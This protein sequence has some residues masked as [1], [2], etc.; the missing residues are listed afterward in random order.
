M[1][2]LYINYYVNFGGGDYS[3]N[4]QYEMQVTEEEYKA[5]R[6]AYINEE[7]L[8]NDDYESIV[9]DVLERAEEEVADYEVEEYGYEE[10]EY[11]P[12]EI[13]I[14]VADMQ[15]L[16][17]KGFEPAVDWFE[18]EYED[19][20]QEEKFQDL[21]EEDMPLLLD[22][23]EN[24]DNE[25]GEALGEEVVTQLV[26]I[27]FSKILKVL[28][29]Q[30]LNAEELEAWE[31]PEE[32]ADS[33]KLSLKNIFD[34]DV[35][36]REEAREEAMEEFGREIRVGLGCEDGP[37]AS[38]INDEDIAIY[39]QDA[40]KNMDT[41]KERLDELLECCEF[42]YEGEQEDLSAALK[43]EAAKYGYEYEVEEEK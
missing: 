34:L 3:N 14:P 36:T 18:E 26:H 1:K 2:T 40:A 42:A 41:F 29:L 43:A 9:C 15:E 19:E 17:A 20:D 33:K 16:V 38:Y 6:L 30:D 22:L 10:D 39:C 27:G 5:C 4:C 37:D 35:Q 32:L 12:E 13:N 25:Y 11:Y 21:E 7:W 28:D 31:M 8:G 23:F 24:D